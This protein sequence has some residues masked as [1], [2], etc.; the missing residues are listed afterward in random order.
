VSFSPD[1]QSKLLLPFF[2]SS[3][4]AIYISN[5]ADIDEVIDKLQEMSERYSLSNPPPF[6]KYNQ[7]DGPGGDIYNVRVEEFQR[8]NREAKYKH[9]V[10]MRDHGMHQTVIPSGYKQPAKLKLIK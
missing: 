9:E 6:Q 8:G 5:S 7:D 4:S 1:R 2:E 3:E 10:F